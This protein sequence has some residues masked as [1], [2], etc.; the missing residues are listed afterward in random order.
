MQDG[1]VVGMEASCRHQDHQNDKPKLHCKRTLRFARHGGRE[2]TQRK[3]M[4]WLLQAGQYLN[5][6]DHVNQC[7]Y[8]P[9]ASSGQV[10]PS[11]AEME[12]MSL[13]GGEG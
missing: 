9:T 5:R 2:E 12:L 4:W 8:M 3:L 10:M 11:I 7:P 1:V 6:K 13:P